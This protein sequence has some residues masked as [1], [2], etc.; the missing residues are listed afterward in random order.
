MNI[1]NRQRPTSLFS[2]LFASLSREELHSESAFGFCSSP[3]RKGS[4][5]LA[6][7]ATTLQGRVRAPTGKPEQNQLARI[8]ITHSVQRKHEHFS[9][10]N[11]AYQSDG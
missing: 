11:P 6:D 8:L 3:D 2:P 1:E 5:N 7:V 9:H 4:L 10:V